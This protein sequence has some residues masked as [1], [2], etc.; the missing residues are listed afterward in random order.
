[1]NSSL[2]CL[3]GDYH[4]NSLAVWSAYDY[5]LAVATTVNTGPCHQLAWDPH[6][7]YEFV[8]VGAA[9]SVCFWILEERGNA[10]E[11]KVNWIFLI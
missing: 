7:A 3:T 1:M 9:M 4:D 6:T 11:L 5:T 2:S 10:H 8:T